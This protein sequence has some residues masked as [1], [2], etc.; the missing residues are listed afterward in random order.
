MMKKFYLVIIALFVSILLHAESIDQNEAQSIAVNYIQNKFVSARRAISNTDAS[1]ADKGIGHKGNIG[2]Y[3][4]NIN[5]GGFVIVSADSRS[6][7]RVLGYSTTGKYDSEKMPANARWLMNAFALEMTSLDNHSEAI[8]RSATRRAATA[9]APLLGETEWNQLW[10]YNLQTPVIDGTQAPTGCVATAIAQ[11][12]YYHKWPKQ[13]KG[14][15]S[16]EWEGMTFSADF[17]QSTYRWDLMLPKYD[18]NS[19]KESCEAVALLMHD[20][21]IASNMFYGSGDSGASSD[22]SLPGMIK[23]FDYDKGIRYIEKDYC[24][25]DSWLGFIQE[26][27]TKQRPIIYD[28]GGAGGAHSMVIDGIDADGLFHVNYGWGGDYNGYFAMGAIG[29]DMHPSL[30]FNIKPNEGGNPYPTFCSKGDYI[31]DKESNILRMSDYA[32]AYCPGDREGE[33]EVALAVENKNSLTVSYV[34]IV[35]NAHFHEHQP[36][37]GLDDGEYILYPVG[38]W[39]DSQEWK[40]L[41]FADKL[42]TFVDLSVKNGVYEFANNHINDELDEGKI[43]YNGIYYTL[44]TTT[45]EAT[46]TYKN[47]KKNSYSGDVNIPSTFNYEGVEY[48]VA[49]IGY[50]AFL[51]HQRNLKTIYVPETVK[52]LDAGCF[53]CNVEN[54]IFAKNSNIRNISGFAFNGCQIR[55]LELPEGVTTLEGNSFQSCTVENLIL[56]STVTSIESGAF[57]YATSLQNLTVKWQQPITNVDETSF[58]NVDLSQVTLHVPMGTTDLYKNA[59]VW[60]NF[61]AIVEDEI[62]PISETEEKSFSQQVDETTDLQNTVIDNTYYNMD[63]TNGDGYDVTE[64]ALVLNSTTSSA[65]MSAVQGAQVGDAAVRENFSGIIFELLAGQGVITVDAKTIGTHVLNVQIG[66]GAPTQ[67]KK[68]ERGTVEVEYNVSAPTYVYLYAS[69]E[70]GASARLYRGPSAGANSVLLYGYKVQVGGT[71]IEELKN[72][73]MEEL[74]YYDLNGRKV[75]TPRKGIYIINGKKVVVK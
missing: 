44:D 1:L 62:V 52:V 42:Q 39:V 3:A 2:Y 11:V 74:K 9:V 20:V 63:A 47:E 29:Y 73:K 21:G 28:G 6:P 26:E 65:Q 27:L 33:F 17:S 16:Y 66:N 41:Y 61:K 10:P 59:P 46:V 40:R 70:S 35:K 14:K 4:F 49:A 30:S 45:K 43:E 75:K 12:M 13:G 69:T 15:Y 67:V 8:K 72:G 64:Q 60:K 25:M 51:G 53:S 22:Y 23:F 57:N 31:Y 19:S 55:S 32:P 38:R 56:P 34:D 37:T 18:S 48:K 36:P 5:G 68:T 71:G 24:S 58:E 7:Q 50:E 54:I